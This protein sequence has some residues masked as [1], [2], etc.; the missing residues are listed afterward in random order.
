MVEK[1]NGGA[2]KVVGMVRMVGPKGVPQ[3]IWVALR[4]ELLPDPLRV[5]VLVASGTLGV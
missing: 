1:E 2:G 3:M 5:Q 4:G